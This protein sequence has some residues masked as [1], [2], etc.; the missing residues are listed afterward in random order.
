MAGCGTIGDVLVVVGLPNPEAWL[1]LLYL[2]SCDPCPCL[3]M[4]SH[5]PLMYVSRSAVLYLT[6]IGRISYIG[7]P[8]F[9][10]S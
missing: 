5:L 10:G 8:S 2:L 3:V 9:S 1:A 7:R 4:H 6:Y